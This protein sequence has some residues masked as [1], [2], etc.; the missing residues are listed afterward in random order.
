MKNYFVYALRSKKDGFLYIGMSFDVQ[1][2]L[3]QHN[4]GKTSSNRSRIPFEVF[5]T[6]EF[7]T[8]GEAREFEKY[9]KSGVGREF[10]KSL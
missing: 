3:D 4:A 2:K 1:K 7:Q 6:R 8:R 10:L 9:L 5:Y